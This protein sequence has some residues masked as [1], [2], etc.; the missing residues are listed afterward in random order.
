MTG[1]ERANRLI[2]VLLG[3]VVRAT[4]ATLDEAFCTRPAVRALG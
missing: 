1:A 4:V 3:Q 2:G